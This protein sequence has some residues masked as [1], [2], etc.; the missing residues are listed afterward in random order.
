M[1]VQNPERVVIK[2]DL[3]DFYGEILPYL[4]GMSEILANKFAKGAMYS[5]EEQVVGEWLDGKILYGKILDCGA[6]PSGA[7]NGYVMA[8]LSEVDHLHIVYGYTDT[9]GIIPLVNPASSVYQ[10]GITYVTADKSIKLYTANDRSGF[11]H[12]YLYIEYTKTVD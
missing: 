3:A 5:T 8:T 10:I 9:S 2:Q 11:G 6:I 12:I 1:S 7:V 4:G